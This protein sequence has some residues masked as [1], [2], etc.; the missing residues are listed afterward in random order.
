VV[1]AASEAAQRSTAL[2]GVAWMVAAAAFFAVLAVTVRELGGRYPALELVFVQAVVPVACLVPWLLR[3]GL[4]G[5]RTKPRVQTVRAAAAFVGMVAMFYALQ[6]MP[7]AD[8]VAFL[9]TTPLFTILIVA[10]AMREPVGLRRGAAV[11]AGFMGALVIVRPGFAEVSWPV[12][13]MALSAFC[14]GVVNAT[15]R[16]LAHHDDA[17][18][19]V[20]YMYAP[21][22][23]LAAAPAFADWRPPTGQDLA[24]F[25]IIG[26][27][28][29]AAQQCITRALLTAPAAVVMP[30]HYLQ[31]PFAAAIGFVVLGESP[32]IWIWVGAAIIA[33]STYYILRTEGR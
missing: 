21:M 14:F 4:A 11:V 28:T 6:W 3:A 26:L 7:V 22:A 1:A 17:N 24:L 2:R 16:M 13:V 15:T 32:D 31:L 30:A 12:A 33:G 23:V 10:A 8:A 29:F 9:F 27:A 20:F 5:L 19:L 18:G 25:A